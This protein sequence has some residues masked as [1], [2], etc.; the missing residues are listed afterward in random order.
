M[1]PAWTAP[2]NLTADIRVKKRHRIYVPEG[3]AEMNLLKKTAA[4]IL[5]LVLVLTG[6]ACSK[7]KALD[8]VAKVAEQLG[9]EESGDEDRLQKDVSGTQDY[10]EMVYCCSDRQRKAQKI[11]DEVFNSSN[12]YPGFDVET[13]AFMYSNIINSNEDAVRENVYIFSF[14]T[15]KKANEFYEILIQEMGVL[16]SAEGKE[17]NYSYAVYVTA[18]EKRVVE[19]GIYIEGNTVIIVNG[20]GY[21]LSDFSLI[22][23]ICKEMDIVSPGAA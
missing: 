19:Q 11:Y 10:N 16:K 21:S 17:K 22:D 2:Q 7:N 4:G 20:S 15:S 18:V 12:T 8:K 13:A 1:S 5:V 9:F 3:E 14:K 23:G 6:T